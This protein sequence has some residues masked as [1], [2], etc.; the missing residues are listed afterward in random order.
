LHI[1]FSVDNIVSVSSRRERRDRERLEREA[2]W[3]AEDAA[4]KAEIG[5]R[6]PVAEP[7]P[8]YCQSCEGRL[9]GSATRCH[10]CGSERL[11]PSRASLPLFS[12]AAV[13]SNGIATC[14]KCKGTQ[15]KTPGMGFGAVTGFM[16]AGGIGA[17][18]GAAATPE[19]IVL[20]ATCGARFKKG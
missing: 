9:K 1:A 11:G 8:L 16:L 3:A 4:V 5:Y 20:C 14:P 15:F 7:P 6:P 19:E 18:L 12:A 2:N 13:V 10:Y 17:I